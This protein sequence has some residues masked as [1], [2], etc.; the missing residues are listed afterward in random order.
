M[1]ARPARYAGHHQM[2]NQA[3]CAKRFWKVPE[4]AADLG[5]RRAAIYR[6]IHFGRLEAFRV[7]KRLVVRADAYEAF[8][9]GRVA[10]STPAGDRAQ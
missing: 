7:G 9:R 4:I 1:R 6:E 5:M 10:A 2:R 8:T 3:Q